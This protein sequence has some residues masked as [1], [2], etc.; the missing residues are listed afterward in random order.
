MECGTRQLEPP[1]RPTVALAARSVTPVKSL[2]TTP[3]PAN[4]MS[5]VAPVPPTQP[6]SSSA[7]PGS[8]PAVPATTTSASTTV[9]TGALPSRVSLISLCESRLSVLSMTSTCNQLFVC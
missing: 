3:I 7:G 5:S 6:R 2:M 1:S 4:T 8:A 9:N